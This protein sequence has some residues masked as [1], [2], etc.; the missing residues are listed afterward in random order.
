MGKLSVGYHSFTF[1]PNNPLFH[2]YTEFPREFS[3]FRSLFPFP[4]I[5]V[6]NDKV[7]SAVF[8][9]VCPGVAYI[10]RSE[11]KVDGNGQKNYTQGNRKGV[12]RST[13][14]EQHGQ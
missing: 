10:R 8:V 14:Y 1:T 11:I 3:A 4:R 7:V 12:G 2:P 6:E 5:R 9:P 13:D